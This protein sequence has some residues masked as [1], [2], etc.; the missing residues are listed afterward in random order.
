MC[1]IVG[2]WIDPDR[3]DHLDSP[4]WLDS[5][6]GSLAHRGPDDQAQWI[7]PRAGLAMGFRR[8]SILDPSPRGR[9]PRVSPSGDWVLTLNG[10][11]YNHLELRQDLDGTR[12]EGTSDSET[13]AAAF[14]R[15]GVEGAIRR[16]RGMFSIA[17]WQTSTRSL[18]LI[19]DRI[20]VKPL[21]WAEFPG[22]MAWAS[23]VRAFERLPVFDRRVDWD[24][25]RQMLRRF[26]VPAPKSIYAN[27]RKLMPGSWIEFKKRLPQPAIRYWSLPSEPSDRATE[28]E[29]AVE[30]AEVRLRESVRLRMLSDVPLGAF[31][32]GGI[33]SSLVVAL[34]Q[35][36]SAAPVR[37]F[38]IGFE[39]PEFDEAPF[40]RRIARYLGTEHQEWILGPQDLF[41]HVP[42]LAQV[43][44][45]PFGDSSQIPTC[46][47]C[48]RARASVTVALSGD[49]GD[50]L[51]GGY[52]R[53]RWAQSLWRARG[54]L[55]IM[56]RCIPALAKLT[57]SSAFS[58]LA[59]YPNLLNAPHFAAL[60]DR[61]MSPGLPERFFRSPESPSS[62]SEFEGDRLRQMQLADL[63]DYLPNDLL[64]KVDR[65]SMSCGLEVREPVLDH[66]WVEWAFSL[67]PSLQPEPKAILRAV[68]ARHV[69]VELWSRP[70]K[71]FAVPLADWLRG[72]LRGWG[73][74]LIDG[75]LQDVPILESQ[76]VRRLWEALVAGKTS[77]SAAIWPVLMLLAWLEARDPGRL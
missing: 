75:R 59:K 29:E 25:A 33:D 61:L 45:E 9:Q 30:Q 6:M 35:S 32:S 28:F 69:P 60:Y 76:E 64:V 37:T 27:A 49:G 7:D 26:S 31:L 13:L 8:L 18:T 74:A 66:P 65:A 44:D 58:F 16:I 42:R 77:F 43:Y 70:K 36:L 24:A 10:E 22:G 2:F 21:L 15:W 57:S 38:T 20:G 68:L 1:G 51:F 40:A 3:F 41:E 67:P 62:I 48:E 63:E 11:I 46:A 50:E 56:R 39:N 73:Q 12:W 34:M 55:R 52:D 4:L 19:R 23:E 5:M 47:L 71:G 54:P 53:Y 14:D 17:V 72:P